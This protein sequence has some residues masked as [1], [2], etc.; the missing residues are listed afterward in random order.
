M[1]SLASVAPTGV[2]WCSATRRR[3]SGFLHCLGERGDP[4]GELMRE[5]GLHP[6]CLPHDSRHFGVPLCLPCPP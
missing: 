4:A 2:W 6:F 5:M 1:A 3:V